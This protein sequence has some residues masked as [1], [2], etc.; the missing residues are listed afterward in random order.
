MGLRNL[1]QG[2][3]LQVEEVTF[4]RKMISADDVIAASF[5][6]FESF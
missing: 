3:G 4:M 1:R 5:A 6:A 2:G